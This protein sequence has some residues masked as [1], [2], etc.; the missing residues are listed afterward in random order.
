MRLVLST[1][2]LL[3]AT[4][5]HAQV[6]ADRPAPV[7]PTGGAD[8]R[9]VS[10]ADAY[11]YSAA[12]TGGAVVLGYV[13]YRTLPG[14]PTQDGS[15]GQ[16]L[17]RA[18]IAVGVIGGPSVGNAVLGAGSDV[19]RALLIKGAGII[20]GA[21]L[22]T[23]AFLACIDDVADCGGTGTFLLVGALIA[24]GAGLVVG[25]VYDLATIPGNARAARWG[26]VAVGLGRGGVPTVGLRV[27]L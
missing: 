4:A 5:P 14:A 20:V 21:G 11:L 2:A 16:G 19:R 18:L 23:A 9:D 17:G 10:A 26:G 25:T 27:G 13:L 1:L 6:L 8:V 15:A 22:G 24:G 7:P 12:V 3:L